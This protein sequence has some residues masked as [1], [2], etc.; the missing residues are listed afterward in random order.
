MFDLLGDMCARHQA[1]TL[2]VV[3]TASCRLRCSIKLSS[4]HTMGQ[5]CSLQIDFLTVVLQRPAATSTG[6]IRCRKFVIQYVVAPVSFAN[7]SA[8]TLRSLQEQSI[9]RDF[10][11]I[12]LCTDLQTCED[13]RR[14]GQAT[15]H[16][17]PLELEGDDARRRRLLIRSSDLYI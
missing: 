14:R 10:R 2:S 7:C 1:S 3:H 5:A 4:T 17:R 8:R 16:V 12:G 13:K 6:K 15:C 11:Q 9:D